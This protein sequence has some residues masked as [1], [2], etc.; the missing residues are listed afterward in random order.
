MDNQKLKKLWYDPGVTK[1]FIAKALGVSRYQLDTRAKSLGLPL[2]RSRSVMTHGVSRE[3]FQRVWMD[4]SLTKEQASFRLGIPKSTCQD[5]CEVY[6]LPKSREGY[7]W[8]GGSD[9]DP[10]PEEIR[11]ACL[12]IQS[13]WSEEEWDARERR[14][15]PDLRAFSYTGP[16]TGFFEISA[17]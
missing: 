9:K 17:S 11:A 10:T 6:G 8:N 14:R 2:I 13:R 3:E 12:E 7:R 1:E 16:M 4:F 15:T 5:L